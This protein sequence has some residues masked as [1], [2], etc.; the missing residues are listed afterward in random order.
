M[1]LQELGPGLETEAHSVG[2]QH[3]RRYEDLDQAN[4]VPATLTLPEQ[5]QSPQLTLPPSFGSSHRSD[6]PAFGVQ[7]FPL[8]EVSSRS[9]WACWAV[10]VS[11]DRFPMPTSFEVNCS[12]I[13]SQ[14]AQ[15]D[16]SVCQMLIT[17]YS[18]HNSVSVTCAEWKFLPNSWIKNKLR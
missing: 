7:T 13:N 2:S 6:T 14:L 12:K 8:E 9:Y 17:R 10:G 15:S 4:G 18:S 5:N 11:P 3:T 1:D 16:I